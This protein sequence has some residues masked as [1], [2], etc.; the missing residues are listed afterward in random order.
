MVHE[1]VTRN[2]TTKVFVPYGRAAL[3]TFETA[4][5]LTGLSAGVQTF[6][7]LSCSVPA[8]KYVLGAVVEPEADGPVKIP[9]QA[10]LMVLKVAVLPF[11]PVHVSST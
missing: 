11:A 6:V 1:L 3:R 8:L 10:E 9:A 7:P 2:D 4:L 5:F